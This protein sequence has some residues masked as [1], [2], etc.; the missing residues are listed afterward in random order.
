MASELKAGSPEYEKHKKAEIEHY[1]EVFSD[2][3]K[4]TD[5][6][7]LF[8]PVPQAWIEIETRA[9]EL[10][11]RST[12]HDAAGHLVQRLSNSRKRMLSLGS[13]PGGIELS[14]A[15]VVPG[16][17]ITCTDFNPVLLNLGRQRASSEGLSV[18]FEQMDLN[19]IALPAAEYDIV[20]CHA[21]LHHV[22]ELERL[23]EQIR[24][25]LRPGGELIVVDV[26]TPSGYLMFPETREVVQNL[27]RT[28]PKELR[29]N[30]TAHPS[31]PRPDRDIWETDTSE[32]GME[33]IRSGDILPTLERNFACRDFVPYFSLCRR[34]FDTMYGPNYDLKNPLHW[35]VLNFIWE[36]DCFYIRAGILRPETFFAIYTT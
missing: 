7:R 23:A 35:S 34:F 26:V 33:C 11:K 2:F 18:Q 32:T 21:A 8:Q 19:T 16:A 30:H 29:V 27:W 25:C 9:A 15:S 12:G 20:F 14:V 10:I 22:I 24:R 6:R 36:L 28:L 13:G 17:D 1:A 5:D 3:S 4:S 31:G